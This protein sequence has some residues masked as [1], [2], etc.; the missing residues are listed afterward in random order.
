MAVGFSF[1][2]PQN[3]ESFLRDF[4]R[5]YNV[6]DYYWKIDNMQAEVWTKDRKHDFFSKTIYKGPE[7]RNL[8][9]SPSFNIFLKLEA[10]TSIP[11]EEHL[12]TFSEYLL[13]SCR[14]MMLMD[15]C[16]NV[17]VYAKNENDLKT[18]FKTAQDNNYLNV[19]CFEKNN[20]PRT[21][22]DLF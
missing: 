7:F 3:I 14:L 1:E 19:T 9:L 13:S 22:L 17:V 18:L 2:L 15:D 10:Y 11:T 12:H 5:N 16:E 20:N 6:E 21:G 4:F 8:I